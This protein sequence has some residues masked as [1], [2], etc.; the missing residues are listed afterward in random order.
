MAKVV[1]NAKNN[2]KFIPN[3]SPAGYKKEW[4]F[5]FSVQRSAFGVL[6][7]VQVSINRHGLYVLK[8]H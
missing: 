6:R 5:A 2:L 3:R 1:K 8:I 7:L 4:G